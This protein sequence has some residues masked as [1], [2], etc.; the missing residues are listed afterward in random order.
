MSVRDKLRERADQ[1]IFA[2]ETLRTVIEWINSTN[3]QSIY[4][5]LQ[6]KGT[7]VALTDEEFRQRFRDWLNASGDFIAKANEL[8]TLLIEDSINIMKEV[9]RTA[10]QKAT[11]ESK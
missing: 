1:R 10:Q 6:Q 5:Q 4:A 11:S 9:T 8:P 7:T 3:P 2:L